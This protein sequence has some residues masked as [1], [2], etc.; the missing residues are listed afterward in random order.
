MAQP[1]LLCAIS[2]IVPASMQVRIV[3][4]SVILV[5]IL[6][7]IATA[8]SVAQTANQDPTITDLQRQ[9]Q[10]MRLQM[11]KMQ[12]RIADLEATKETAEKNSSTDPILPQSQT[13]STEDLR[14]QLGEVR[15]D[16][17]LLQGDYA[18][19]GRL[20]GINNSGPYSQRKC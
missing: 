1:T 8:G 9:I 6:M 12:N 5:S 15:A 4:R 11:A 19:P 10:E 13:P 7:L 14:S 2:R 18:D 16:F 3:S 20:S 17:V